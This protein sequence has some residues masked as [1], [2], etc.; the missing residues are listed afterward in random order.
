MEYALKHTYLLDYLPE[1]RDWLH[2]DKDWVCNVLNSVDY[3]G[4]SNMILEARKKRKE[5]LET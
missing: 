5:K 3:Q 2:V 4:I 1:E